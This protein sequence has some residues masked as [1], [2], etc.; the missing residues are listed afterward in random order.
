MHS[1]WQRPVSRR[2]ATALQNRENST[3]RIRT[4]ELGS[5]SAPAGR[6]DK[7]SNGRPESIA[8]F[9]QGR[10]GEIAAT[11][12][13]VSSRG[14]V[15]L[16]RRSSSVSRC[17]GNRHCA[18]SRSA[19]TSGI[20][21]R[22]AVNAG[23]EQLNDARSFSSFRNHWFAQEG[24]LRAPG[25]GTSIDFKP[26]EVKTGR[27]TGKP[28]F[29]RSALLKIPAVRGRGAVNRGPGLVPSLLIQSGQIRFF[30]S[31]QRGAL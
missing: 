1:G 30:T 13:R 12:R 3:A 11:A 27:E 24:S 28:P 25:R 23:L 29:P 17:V 5:S 10:G 31:E 18:G 8:L 6:I 26:G 16:P 7:Q 15:M 2:D 22:A 21:R 4:R 20:A 14:M 9:D 19:E